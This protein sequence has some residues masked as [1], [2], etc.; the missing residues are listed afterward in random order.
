M[1]AIHKL[2]TR[3]T[4]YA[5]LTLWYKLLYLTTNTTKNKY[6]NE[7][8]NL[9]TSID[10]DYLALAEEFHLCVIHKANDGWYAELWHSDEEKQAMKSNPLHMSCTAVDAKQITTKHPSKEVLLEAL[11]KDIATFQEDSKSE[12]RKRRNAI[13]EGGEIDPYVGTTRYEAEALRDKILVNG[14]SNEL[15]TLETHG[16]INL[17]STDFSYEVT[18]GAEDS[19]ETED[20]KDDS[21]KDE[22]TKPKSIWERLIGRTKSTRLLK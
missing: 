12:S 21:A 2:L 3:N 14:R 1:T 22:A 10:F 15:Q 16:G 5:S 7:F 9:P 18:I 13:K 11:S 4:F 6:G 8:W 17:R 20:V 19:V